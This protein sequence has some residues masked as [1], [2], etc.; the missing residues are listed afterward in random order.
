MSFFV[1]IFGNKIWFIG[2][3]LIFSFAA[4]AWEPRRAL[5]EESLVKNEQDFLDRLMQL[6]SGGDPFAKNSRSSAVGAFQFIR[7]T[8]LEVVQRYFADEIAGKSKPEILQLRVDPKFARRA[9][10]AYTRQ[11][12]SFLYKHGIKP[13]PGHLR[14]A[15]LLGP[16]GA[17]KVLSADPKKPL[18]TLL[19]SKVIAANPYMKLMTAH[20]IIQRS[21]LDVSGVQV[22]SPTTDQYSL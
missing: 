20:E 15:F 17:V 9:A 14:L 4:S 22:A 6:E 18:S 5:S 16:T 3:I 19:S 12:A 2:L 7:S 21:K 11:N 8:F 1:G 10:L 13:E